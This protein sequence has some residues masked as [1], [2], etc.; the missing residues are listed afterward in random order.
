MGKK[1][2]EHIFVA[3]GIL[4]GNAVLA[5][6][7]AGFVLPQGMITGGATGL[8][9]IT[10]RILG[11]D[12]S[13]A[14]AC[15]NLVLF[16]VGALVLG[17]KFALTT[18]IS[19]LVYPV[20]LSV[21][22]QMEWVCTLTGNLMLAAVYAGI[23]VGLG[24]GI[25][26]RLGASTGGMDIP[27][28]IL[29]KKFGIPV[30]VSM[31]LF[32]SA[33][34]LLQAFYSDKEQILY[35]ILIVILSSIMLNYVSLAGQKKIQVMIVSKHYLEIRDALLQKLDLGATMFYIETGYLQKHE[36]AV[37]CVASSRKLYAINEVV[38]QIDPKAFTS[39]TQINEVRGRGF[40]LDRKYK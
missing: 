27:P 16:V 34:L 38:Q 13:V 31:Y 15:Y 32:D 28:L 9:I 40:T 36:M 19:T 20:F 7:I 26:I 22:S 10:N 29:N 2:G 14:V 37:C 11:I 30:A 18:I 23:L 39:I 33:I 25:V 5:F 24:V 12:V 8:G 3:F 21:F 1:I 35:G 4:F 17:K 6:G